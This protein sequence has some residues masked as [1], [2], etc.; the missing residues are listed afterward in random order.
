MTPR[1]L[2]LDVRYF[3]NQQKR[4]GFTFWVVER[5]R[6]KLF[7][8]FC[9]LVRVDEISSTVLGQVEIGWRIR[10]DIWR[11]GY[12]YEAALSVLRFGFER[13]A[14]E[15][16]VARVAPGNSASRGLMEK[17]GMRRLPRLDYVHPAD[18]EKLMLYGM[19]RRKLR[20]GPPSPPCRRSR[21][22]SRA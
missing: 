22:T 6:D 19:S 20:R 17:L 15:R 7:L 3:R 21:Q 9:G 11:R 18:G 12:A 10:S 2:Q 16:I 8:G 5:K 4:N 14:I 1:D 13:L